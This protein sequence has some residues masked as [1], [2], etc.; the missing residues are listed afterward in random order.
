MT[1][2][3][4]LLNSK[5][6]FDNFLFA[7]VGEDKKGTVVSVLTAFAR[8]DFDPWLEAADLARLPKDAATTR[9]SAIIATLP[10]ISPPISDP[11]TLA[12]RLIALLSAASTPPSGPGR[13][14]VAAGEDWLGAFGPANLHSPRS[15]TIM[16]LLAMWLVSL[17]VSMSSQPPSSDP[18]VVAGTIDPQSQEG[19]TTPVAQ[20]VPATAPTYEP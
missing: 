18:P 1:H 8:L 20:P 3:A 14:T 11:D 6:E 10:G 7:P 19:P 16:L 9:L 13:S 17:V 2:S 12:A 15:M 4:S 5:S